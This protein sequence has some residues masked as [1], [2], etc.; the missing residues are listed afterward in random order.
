MS[1][2]VDLGGVLGAA[3]ERQD[4]P[5]VAASV[6]RAGEVVWD[7]YAGDAAPGR[8]VAPDTVFRLFSM[9]KAVGALATMIAVDRSLLS[10]ETPVVSV[11]PQF[12]DIGVL[13]SMGPSGPVLRRPRTP[14]TL[15]HL[16]THTSGFAYATWN[17]AQAEF[18]TVTGTAH[19]LS[20]TL[21]SLHNPLHFEPGEGFAYGMGYDWA[22]L[23]L[24][25]VV[26]RRV[27]AFCQEEIFDPLGMKD[28]T[29]DRARGAH[30]LA[31][32]SR[33]DEDGSFEGMDLAPGAEP[34]F[35]GFGGALYGTAPDYVRFLRMVLGRG[36]L[37][38]RHIVS[39]EVIEP[40]LVNQLGSAS[41]PRLI[42]TTSRAADVDLFPGSRTTHTIGFYRN[43]SDV[44]GGRSAGSLTWAGGANTHFWVDPARD[45]AAVFMTQS[46]P[47]R[48]PRFLGAYAA[49]ERAVYRTFAG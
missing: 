5:F 20:G 36:E 23:M 40:M 35:H 24:E 43:E 27:D 46:F 48:E 45:I 29:F 39:R 8:Q 28:T 38:G 21:A 42:T 18:Q 33:R 26:G 44:P 4:V 19:A 3:V 34:E 14:V 25:K 17:A 30:R 41:V 2:L 15:R 32:L 9:T 10:L 49:F 47:F 37:D 13:E 6:A 12:G 16:L 7:G 31:D 11:L 1:E 22:G